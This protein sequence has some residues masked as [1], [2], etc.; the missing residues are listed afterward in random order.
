MIQNERRKNGSGSII[1]SSII[2]FPSQSSCLILHFSLLNRHT[3]PLHPA[4]DTGLMLFTVV[5]KLIRPIILSSMTPVVALPCSAHSKSCVACVS[6]VD[7]F[8]D[9]CELCAAGIGQGTQRCVPRTH[10]LGA[11]YENGLCTYGSFVIPHGS[12]ESCPSPGRHEIDPEDTIAISAPFGLIRRVAEPS[13][14]K[15]TKSMHLDRKT[16][17]QSGSTKVLNFRHRPTGTGCRQEG[18]WRFF[19]GHRCKDERSIDTS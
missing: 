9:V 16:S 2:T 13:I 17:R 7:G 12:V 1:K 10:D 18:W 6:A 15:S 11:E 4:M 19:F 5:L 14:P 8:G 3:S